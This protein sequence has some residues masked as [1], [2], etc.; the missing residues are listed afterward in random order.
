VDNDD[1]YCCLDLFGGGK[2]IRI[3]NETVYTINYVKR[4]VRPPK[5]LSEYAAGKTCL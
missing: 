1:D 3:D 5:V 2:D 4:G